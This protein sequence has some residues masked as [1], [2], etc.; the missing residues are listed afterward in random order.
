METKEAD[1]T[2]VVS[3]TDAALK[4]VQR[5]LDLQG[6]TDGGLRLGV[7]G[8]GCSG[9]S[10]TV[11]FDEK[12]G[13][14]DTVTEV[15]GV[16]VRP[17]D[18][19]SKLLFPK[20]TYEPGEEEFTV[21]RVIVKGIKDERPVTHTYDLYDEYDRETQTSSMSRTTAFPATIMGRMLLN[22]TIKEP[23]VFTPEKIAALPGLFD[24]MI[25]ELQ[26]RNVQLSIDIQTNSAS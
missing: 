24:H 26:N 25:K 18:V 17:L 1:N 20:W 7:K 22:G 21:M 15:N 4:E 9:L 19:T 6:I 10:Y 5:L 13:E 23:G 16:K 8:G 2:A 12:I 14:F 11:N 3:M